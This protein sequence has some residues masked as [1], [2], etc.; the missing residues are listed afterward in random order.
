MLL[1]T[2]KPGWKGSSAILHPCLYF[3]HW[4]CTNNSD[5]LRLRRAYL[6]LQQKV[7]L[8]G[9]GIAAR[10]RNGASLSE[11]LP[12]RSAFPSLQIQLP[13]SAGQLTKVLQGLKHTFVVADATLPD[14]PLVFASER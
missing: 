9:A 6:F 11:L 13:P 7:S 1:W 10:G 12:P 5:F 8:N 14:I 3:L 2:E 4:L